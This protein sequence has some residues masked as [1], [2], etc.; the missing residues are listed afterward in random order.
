MIR[1]SS[2][3]VSLP[4][5]PPGATIAANSQLL[6]TSSLVVNVLFAA[7]S[8]LAR[9][10]SLNTGACTPTRN[11]SIALS[12]PFP[13]SGHVTCVG[14]SKGSTLRELKERGGTEPS[15]VIHVLSSLPDNLLPF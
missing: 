4:S 9:V 10:I 11:L 12:V 3:G 2:L 6:N 5:R 8:S 1:I 7:E 15:G 14:T 13:Q